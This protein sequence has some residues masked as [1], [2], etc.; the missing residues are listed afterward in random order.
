MFKDSVI[1]N[2]SECLFRVFIKFILVAPTSHRMMLTSE[3]V[4]MNNGLTV[5]RTENTPQKGHIFPV[6]LHQ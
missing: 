4:I 3:E 2:C 5:N 6:V 1:G